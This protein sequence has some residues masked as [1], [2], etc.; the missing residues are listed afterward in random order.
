MKKAHVGSLLLALVLWPSLLRA[1]SPPTAAVWTI[2][3]IANVPGQSSTHFVSDVAVTNPGATPAMAF[4]TVVPGNLLSAV[5]VTLGPGQ[6]VVWRNVLQQLFG[7][8]T[9]GALQVTSDGTPLLIRARTY[10]DSLSGT[11]GV[12]LPVFGTDGFLLEGDIGHSLW[13][14]QSPDPTQG[15]R[16][17]IA[18]LF[19]DAGGGAATVTVFDG[20]GNQIGQTDFSLASAGVQQ[21]GI[22]KFASAANVAR[23]TIEVKSGRAAG[24]SSVVDNVTGDSSLFTFDDL[25]AGPQDVLINGVARANGKNGTFFRTDGRF[26][27]SGSLDATVKPYFLASGASNP[28]PAQGSFTVPAGKVLD[29]TDV[30][31]TFFGLAPPASGAIRFQSD[32]PVAILCRTSNVDP[33]GARPGTFGAQ[34]K[35]VP[36]LS[37]LSS[38][39]AGALITGVRQNAAYRTNIGLAAGGD[40]ASVQFKLMTSQGATVGTATQTLGAYGWSQTAVD[41]LFG[42][43]TPDDAEILVTLTQGSADVFDSSVDNLSG[44]SVVTPAPPL[45][46]AIPT[47]ATIGPAGGSIR[48]DDGRLTLKIPAGALA[49]MTSFSIATTSNGAPNGLEAAYDI[50]P[51]NLTFSKPALL[52]FTYAS[53]DVNGTGSGNLGLAVQNGTDW[54]GIGGGAIDLASGTLTVLLSSTTPAALSFPLSARTPLAAGSRRFA[55][56]GA[57]R[58]DPPSPICVLTRHTRIL[59]VSCVGPGAA[60]APGLTP[61]STTVSP[62]SLGG[63]WFVDGKAG[64]LPGG[65]GGTISGSM[66]ATYT[67]PSNFTQWSSHSVDVKVTAPDVPNFRAVPL[68]A[69]VYVVPQNLL[70]YFKGTESVTCDN[71]SIPFEI[72][73]TSERDMALTVH[74]DFSI[75]GEPAS[76]SPVDKITSNPCA[77]YNGFTGNCSNQQLVGP[78]LPMSVSNVTGKYQCHEIGKSQGFVLYLAGKM[79]KSPQFTAT[80]Y[81]P[82][83]IVL[84]LGDTMISANLPPDAFFGLDKLISGDPVT[85]SPVPNILSLSLVLKAGGF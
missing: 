39:D 44:D 30:L 7:L 40:G 23:A 72:S 61:L 66:T 37:F 54:L 29:V 81:A 63:S 83:P 70:L 36:L 50:S 26:Y 6:T 13:V 4:V 67:A 19:P 1:Q 28:S 58:I 68:R 33:T 35:P 38:A 84:P 24:Y 10:N 76:T 3:G 71:V 60:A 65:E 51:D 17:N 16:T 53:T 69:K 20:D 34:Q 73:Y 42:V 45:P 11:Y 21:V 5:P 52:V 31:W 57:V 41:K 82:N 62:S 64:G 59:K 12:A 49:S 79:N 22:G 56:Y 9:S 55:P 15:Y 48:S 18:V 74:D 2:P 78:W 25:P 77:I 32:A 46:V 80:C 43:A 85:T 75:T 14:S 27:N 47:S 8:S